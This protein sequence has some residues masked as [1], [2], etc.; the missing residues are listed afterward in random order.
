MSNMQLTN[1]RRIRKIEVYWASALC[2]WNAPA[3]PMVLDVKS[4][5]RRPLEYRGDGFVWI[6]GACL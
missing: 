3:G 2:R 4:K 1:H 5:M 6:A